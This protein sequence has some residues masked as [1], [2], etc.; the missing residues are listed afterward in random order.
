MTILVPHDGSELSAR[1]LSPA[2]VLA[3]RLGEAL[4]I[5]AVVD[6]ASDT[7]A[8]RDMLS[9][10]AAPLAAEGIPY[11]VEVRAGTAADEIVNAAGAVKAS[12][13]V[14]STHGRSGIS[15]LVH[16]STAASVIHGAT[17][18]V[19]AVPPQ[20]T[21]GSFAPKRIVL[22][23]E[24]PEL[25]AGLAELTV[26]MA[27]LFDAELDVVK[28]VPWTSTVAVAA[29]AGLVAAQIEQELEGEAL[30]TVEQVRESLGYAKSHGSVLRG[31]PGA[32]LA[33]YG[34]TFGAGLFVMGTRARAGLARMVLGS[35]AEHV[36]SQAVAPVLLFRF[37][38]TDEESAAG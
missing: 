25:P 37:G 38:A 11:E 26:R 12:L 13:I 36:I 9:D 1:A 34:R 15:R 3:G 19:L 24:Q 20:E 6:D 31:S 17:V 33:N 2:R 22:P 18:P 35:T 8:T 23:V 7:A 21:P 29:E 10:F 4:H 5:L 16:G 32:E 28:V 14:M 30:H 27:G